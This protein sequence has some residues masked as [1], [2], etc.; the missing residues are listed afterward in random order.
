MKKKCLSKKLC[1]QKKFEVNI[2]LGFDQ[3]WVQ[4]I[5][6]PKIKIL[7]SNL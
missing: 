3:F 5:V 1:A 6:G 7:E 4:T 2:L